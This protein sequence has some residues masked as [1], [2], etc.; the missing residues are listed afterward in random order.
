MLRG[1]R[2]AGAPPS[3]ATPVR[4]RRILGWRRSGGLAGPRH[5][6]S[7]CAIRASA[8]LS[9]RNAGRWMPDWPARG[10]KPEL[11]SYMAEAPASRD[12]ESECWPVHWARLG[13][14]RGGGLSRATDGPGSALG[15]RCSPRRAGTPSGGRGLARRAG[16]AT[17]RRA[18][19]GQNVEVARRGP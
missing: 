5:R 7:A 6:Q 9:P 19:V 10:P 8:G 3:P 12:S 2:P 11:I 18:G 4:R 1:A 13:R 17:A 14:R 15:V 16:R